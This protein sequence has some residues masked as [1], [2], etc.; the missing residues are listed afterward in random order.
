MN[1][2]YNEVLAELNSLQGS[3]KNLTKIREVLVE[4]K[5]KYSSLEDYVC[6]LAAFYNYMNIDPITYDVLIKYCKDVFMSINF[7]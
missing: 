7:I 6:V 4:K 5:Q 3:D 2:V 1:S